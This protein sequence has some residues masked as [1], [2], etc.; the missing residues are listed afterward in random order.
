MSIIKYIPPYL[1]IHTHIHT[2]LHMFSLHVFVIREKEEKESH[3]R[4]FYFHF[5]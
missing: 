4:T 5:G 3:F 1:Y 2:G